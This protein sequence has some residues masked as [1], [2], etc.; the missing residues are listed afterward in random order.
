[1]VK[2]RLFLYQE[3]KDTIF[4]KKGNLKSKKGKT[5]EKR[6]KCRKHTKYWKHSNTF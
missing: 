2:E 1:M 6:Q 5:R 3:G 4:L